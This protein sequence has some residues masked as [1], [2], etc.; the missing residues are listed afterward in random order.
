MTMR[1]NL[2]SILRSQVEYPINE[3]GNHDTNKM[4]GCS[5]RLGAG[6]GHNYFPD[7]VDVKA[8]VHSMMANIHKHMKT[9]IPPRKAVPTIPAPIAEISTSSTA[10][11]T[12]NAKKNRRIRGGG[13]GA[14]AAGKNSTLPLSQ[15][16]ARLS[17]QSQ[18]VM[19]RGYTE[20][21]QKSFTNQRRIREVL[22]Q[23]TVLENMLLQHKRLQRDRQTIAL[24]I[25]QMRQE[26]DKIKN[27]LDTS[28]QA[29]NSTRTLYTGFIKGKKGLM[30]MTLPT[31]VVNSGKPKSFDTKMSSVSAKSQLSVI[32]K[33][34]N[35]QVKTK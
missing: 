15:I 1:L 10:T 11:K 29:L 17:R 34:R 13:V 7:K 19:R 3:P 27:R 35:R 28:Q 16:K 24:E 2:G 22:L 30:P 14:L 6:G 4:D 9:T 12:T 5:L 18:Q 26:L 33:R 25:Q 21:G 23:K 32:P 20:I 31:N 8:R